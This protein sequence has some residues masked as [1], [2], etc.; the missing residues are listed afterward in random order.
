MTAYN[1]TPPEDILTE[2]IGAFKHHTFGAELK[3]GSCLLRWHELAHTHGPTDGMQISTYL[4]GLWRKTE[5]R[6]GCAVSFQ[7]A[8]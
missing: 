4:Q 3:P 2:P 8:S 1:A 5:E 6:C 7:L